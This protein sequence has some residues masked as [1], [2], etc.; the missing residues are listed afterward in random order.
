MGI[1]IDAGAVTC[2]V[3]G[4][5]GRLEYAIIGDPV[6]RAAKIQNHTKVEGVRGLTTIAC[7]DHALAQGYMCPHSQTEL[8]DRV[9]AGVSS[10]V[11]LV[12][13]DDA[14]RRANGIPAP[15]TTAKLLN[16]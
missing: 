6:N 9:V 7:R 5:E 3:I 8:P 15:F 11:S 1:G 16:S 12:V 4:D 13:L 10:T 2:G 14:R